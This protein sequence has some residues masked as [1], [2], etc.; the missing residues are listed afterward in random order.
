[1]AGLRERLVIQSLPQWHSQAVSSLKFQ[2]ENMLL[3]GGK[4]AV[5]VQWNLEK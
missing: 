5:L 1:M 4:E 2:S 3:S